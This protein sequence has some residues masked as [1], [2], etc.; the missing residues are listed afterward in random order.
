[1]VVGIA[2]A[3]SGILVA[4]LVTPAGWVLV[5]LGAVMIL[6]VPLFIAMAVGLAGRTATKRDGDDHATDM[7]FVLWMIENTPRNSKSDDTPRRQG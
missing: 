2:L 1:M 6:A 3:A 7:G 5:F 4:L